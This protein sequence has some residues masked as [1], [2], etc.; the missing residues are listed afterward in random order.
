MTTITFDT[1][2]F[3]YTK[4]KEPLVA[5]P[6]SFLDEYKKTHLVLKK[7]STANLLKS[8][9][10]AVADYKAGKLKNWRDTL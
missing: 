9:K 2:M 6:Q 10:Q 7:I 5:V 3:D 4:V 8:G 1:K